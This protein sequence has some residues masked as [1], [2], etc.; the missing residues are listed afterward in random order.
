MKNIDRALLSKT[1]AAWRARSTPS[2]IRAKCFD[3]TAGQRVEIEACDIKTC[4]LWPF[5]MG[6]ATSLSGQRDEAEQLAKTYL[7]AGLVSKEDAE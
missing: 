2:V 4:A 5:R 3:C 7:E 6:H 1:V